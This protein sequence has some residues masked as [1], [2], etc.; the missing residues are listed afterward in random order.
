MPPDG[1]AQ[2]FVSCGQGNHSKAT[3]IYVHFRMIRWSERQLRISVGYNACLEQ[4]RHRNRYVGWF[5][6]AD[7]ALPTGSVVC[8]KH[9]PIRITVRVFGIHVDAQRRVWC[10]FGFSL[11]DRDGMRFTQGDK[12]QDRKKYQ[13]TET[14][15]DPHVWWFGATIKEKCWFYS[16]KSLQ[17][18]LLVGKN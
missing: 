11:V 14:S 6:V 9:G 17:Q 8:E 7:F 3:N 2:G 12:Q 15:Q 10:S 5:L 4:T 13:D 18:K 16:I 1:I